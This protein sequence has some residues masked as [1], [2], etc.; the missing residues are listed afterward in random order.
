MDEE[1]MLDAAIE[2]GCEPDEAQRMYEDF[3]EMYG[4]DPEDVL[5]ANWAYRIKRLTN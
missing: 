5:G 3:V 2:A 4:E 1:T